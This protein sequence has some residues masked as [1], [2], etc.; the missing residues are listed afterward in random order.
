M[1]YADT[2]R[3]EIVTARKYGTADQ[4]AAIAE[5]FFHRTDFSEWSFSG[6]PQVHGHQWTISIRCHREQKDYFIGYDSHRNRWEWNGGVISNARMCENLGVPIS[7]LEGIS[8]ALLH[9]LEHCDNLSERE[10]RVTNAKKLISQK[11]SSLKKRSAALAKKET[12]LCESTSTKR[13]VL[14]AVR[15]ANKKSGE[16]SAAV[17]SQLK[18]QISAAQASSIVYQNNYEDVPTPFCPVPW[19]TGDE[20]PLESGIYFLW[21]DSKIAYV[22]QSIKLGQRVTMS[23][24]RT[25]DGDWVSW[26]FVPIE[27]LDFAECFYIGTTMPPDNFGSRARRLQKA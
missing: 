1:T 12:E 25:R 8:D 15:K 24:D 10:K 21:R 11:T 17:I 5:N 18:S 2:F 6:A 22:G 9:N 4:V 23:H 7:Y 20:I 13:A 16:K 27:E 14:A 19:R 26:V 3:H